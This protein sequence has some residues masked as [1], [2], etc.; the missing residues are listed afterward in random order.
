MIEIIKNNINHKLLIIKIKGFEDIECF[1]LMK[2]LMERYVIV[3]IIDIKQF[4]DFEM[5]SKYLRRDEI[6]RKKKYRK[7]VD[8][9][10]MMVSHGIVNYLFSNWLSCE[11]E[12]LIHNQ[13]NFSKPCI[14][15]KYGIKYNITHSCDLIGIALSIFEVG[16][17]LEYID[18]EIEYKEIIKQCFHKKEQYLMLKSIEDFYCVWVIK[19]AYLKLKGT[20]LHRSLKSLYVGENG[21]LYAKQTEVFVR[22]CC[23]NKVE[24]VNIFNPANE[25]V[26][27][28]CVDFMI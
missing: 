23:S 27:S 25:Y 8:K 19:E 22:D 4:I 21:N 13:G 5:A 3:I 11:P 24:T 14:F 6:I 7:N 12:M 28:I 20:G 18:R 16:I 9:N 10:L 15:N 26:G 1:K 17:D 2:L